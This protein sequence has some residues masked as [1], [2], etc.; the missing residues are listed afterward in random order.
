M[1]LTKQYLRYV[2]STVFGVV[3]SNNAHI[4]Y[5]SLD[6][7]RSNLI[8]VPAVEHVIIW[9][10]RKNEK[11]LI[12][13]GNK[14]EVTA[15]TGCPQSKLLAVGYAD[16]SIQLFD[17]SS[18]EPNIVFNGHKSAVTTL[19]FD[20][21]GLT[22]ASGSKDTDVI[23][24]D[25]VNES[26]L[27]RLKGHKGIVTKCQFMKTKNILITSSK[28]T[29]IK[30]WDLDTQ[31]C[32]KTLVGHRTEVWD[33]ICLDDSKL[34]TGC[35]DSELRVWY[36]NFK[37]DIDEAPESKKAKG[38][39]KSD[40]EDDKV[41]L[42]TCVKAGSIMRLSR[43]RL[44]SMGTDRTG[45]L[46]CC[47]GPE[48]NIEVF[49]IC[50]EEEA[51]KRFKKRQK[52]ARRRREREIEEA[53]DNEEDIPEVEL[54]R[55]A[56]DE[57]K[58]H[59]KIVTSSKVRAFDVL[60]EKND[61]VSLVT[62]LHNNSVE[63]HQMN[64]TDT[65]SENHN[66][67]RLL[68]DGHRSD[69][70]TVC[71]SSDNTAI[72]S[73]SGDSVK[74]WNRDTLKCI[75]SMSC[76]YALCSIFVPG[77][78][79]CIVGT[80]QGTLQLFD[81]AT[82]SLMEQ[83]KA[84]ENTVWSL[85]LMPN[86]RGF[87]SGGTDKTIK[88][89]DFELVDSETDQSKRLSMEHKR[90][91]EMSEDVLCVK[92]SPDQKFIAVS[93]LDSTVKIFFA[94]TLKFF[95][96]LYGHKLPVLTMDIS[97]DSSLIVTG[98]ADKNIKIWGLDYGD[99]HRSIFAHDDSIMGIQFV[100]KTHLFFTCG[101]DRKLKQWDADN[102]E[103]ITTLE[104]HQ[105]EVWCLAVSPS[106]NHIVTASHDKSLRLWQRTEEPLVLEE[107]RE[108]EREKLNEAAV[109]ERDSEPVVAGETAVEAVLAGKQTV[110]TVKAAERIMEA[111]ELFKEE[112]LK[113]IEHREKSKA[114]KKPLPLPKMHP[115]LEA[116]GK[117][118][119]T[120]Y[121]LDVIKKVRSSELE[122]ALLVLPFHYVEDL[123]K[124]LDVF[125]SLE[126]ESELTCRCLLF[127]LRIHHGQITS[128]QVLLPVIDRLRG[129]ISSTVGNMRDTI[130]FNMAALKFLQSE[131]ETKK[132][133]T[134]FTDATDKFQE[135][136]R[137]RKQTRKRKGVALLAL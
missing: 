55:G 91:L 128:N 72:L 116:L 111:I 127:L 120:R 28:D 44:V 132:E 112:R 2:Q 35:G 114:A 64:I 115:I 122:E 81:I 10:I 76:T 17:L 8:A 42:L 129:H 56:E 14:H 93:L 108:N 30:F 59:S 48:S 84:H 34:I 54:V 13:E 121:V 22:L 60:V 137:K 82:G 78:R 21:A 133:V 20:R 63:V 87:V 62:L 131:I 71:F 51:K 105:G 3:A 12:L 5:I 46:L 95:L 119:P 24:W 92:Y 15:L 9:N 27:Y 125:L 52:R 23:L 49:L 53:G 86:K 98:S 11:V 69:V 41:S 47:H 7:E 39:D 123:L 68:W 6:G 1:G 83:I 16:G 75:R 117:V 118:S 97:S 43:E 80:K 130:G 100:P 33:F 40:E 50:T 70:R 110:E 136:G 25:I 38:D 109:A 65:S 89:W 134:F 103:V 57:I 26:G 90:T 101:K 79:H 31:H 88:F 18:G 85:A 74:L 96:S 77:D 58:H 126:W 37:E 102:F 124:L 73:A 29:F 32:F 104:G 4:V 66:I 113:V 45:R 135:A 61:M 94:D 99:C 107:E 36:L 19:T 67:K 106:G